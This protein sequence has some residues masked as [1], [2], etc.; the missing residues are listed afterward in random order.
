MVLGTFS[1]RHPANWIIVGQDVGWLVLSLK[2]LCDSIS[3]YFRPSHIERG[4]KKGE[5]ID[6]GKMSKYLNCHPHLLQAQ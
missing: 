2:A 4:Q 6:E 1:A 3:V 5:K